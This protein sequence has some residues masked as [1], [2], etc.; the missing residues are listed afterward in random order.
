[1]SP[2]P[3]PR[4]PRPVR[5]GEA[6]RRLTLPRRSAELAAAFCLAAAAAADEQGAAALARDEWAVPRAVRLLATSD[7]PATLELAARA[8]AHAATHLDGARRAAPAA[9]RLC[10]LL[11]P[12][13]P[14]AA[15]EAALHALAH[16]AL[17]PELAPAIGAQPDVDENL[18]ALAAAR[19]A[20]ERRRADAVLKRLQQYAAQS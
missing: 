12:A 1:V 20:R 11:A 18:R 5:W 10:A 4:A 16:L 8:L 9:P 14:P 7:A 19:G 6:R 15:R 13:A 17:H 3:P 2:A